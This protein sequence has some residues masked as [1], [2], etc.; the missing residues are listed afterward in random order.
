M[1]KNESTQSARLFYNPTKL[2]ISII[3]DGG[4]RGTLLVSDQ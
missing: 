2:D 3:V 4:G 1:K